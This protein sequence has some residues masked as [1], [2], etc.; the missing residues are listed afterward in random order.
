M[1]VAAL[2]ERDWLEIDVE[3]FAEAV[4]RY[5]QDTVGVDFSDEDWGLDDDSVP[6][7]TQFV[8]VRKL[9]ARY[10]DLGEHLASVCLP[11]IP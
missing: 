9:F 2:T 4:V 7:T 5:L 8:A 6:F 11:A 10:P 3:G 1:D